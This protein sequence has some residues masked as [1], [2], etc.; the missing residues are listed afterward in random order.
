MYQWVGHCVEK[1]GRQEVEQWYWETWNEANTGYWRGTPEEFYKLHDYAVDAVRRA[2][3]TARVGGPDAAG[4]GGQWL[5]NFLEHCL[6]GTNYATGKIGTPLDFVAFHAKGAPTYVDGHVRMGIARQL[7]D[8]QRGFSI[9]AS[10]PELKHTP[11]IIGESDPEGCA[12]C[13][14][15]QLDYRNGTM[16]S[17]YTAAVFARK[18]ELA[19]RY[20]VNL[21]GALTWAFEFENQPYFAGFR[22]L[23]SCGVDLPVLNVFRMFGK[24]GGE[25]VAV[26]SSGAVP[27]EMML[28]EGVRGAPDVSAVA[29]LEPKR[30]TIL[31]W[32]YHDDDV[33]GPDA[34]V[35][36]NV[37]GLPIKNAE[38]HLTHYRV[39]NRHSNAYA[40]WERMGAPIAPGREQYDRLL[41]ASHLA[42][43]EDAPAKAAVRDG[44][45]T[46]KFQLPRQAVSL[47][48][49]DWE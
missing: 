44:T 1:F 13:Q 8:I 5:R 12:A 7:Q 48:V 47:L 41:A 39:D 42:T 30:L 3:P 46:L 9:V 33:P 45:T 36:V 28:K 16:Y 4:G 49:L 40:E 32:H 22:A 27:L 10:F 35:E 37:N 34:A 15:S 25:Q 23:A 31:V 20:G 38:A 24:M 26:K 29:S 43:L 6:H 11:I 2:L 19:A 14:G 18:P 17:S 21:E